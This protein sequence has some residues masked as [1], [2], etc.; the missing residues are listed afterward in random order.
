MHVLSFPFLST[1]FCSL[2]TVW[3]HTEKLREAVISSTSLEEVKFRFVWIITHTMMRFTPELTCQRVKQDWE[4][5]GLS[6][7][8]LTEQKGTA[9]CRTGRF[10]L[11]FIS[12]YLSSLNHFLMPGL[13]LF[14]LM[15]I[16]EKHT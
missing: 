13:F 5:A 12:I 9:D 10:K 16:S 11:P 2:W 7:M 6:G 3:F 14:C 15:L 1:V 8:I 4:S